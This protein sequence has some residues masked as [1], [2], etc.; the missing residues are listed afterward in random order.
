MNY[1][2]SNKHHFE[3]KVSTIEN[4]GRIFEQDKIGLYSSKIKNICDS[5]Y[6]PITKITS[7]GIILIYS[8]YLDS[9]LVPI[10]LTLEEM[11][12]KRFNNPSLF[13]NN[14]KQVD[15][16]TFQTKDKMK[17][18]TFHPASY[19]MITGDKNLSPNNK[20]DIKMV[21]SPK[22]KNGE[23]VKI[24]LISKAGSEGIDFKNIR[25][26]HLLDPWYNM[27]RNDQT[28]GR[29]VRNNS[30]T[31]LPFIKRNVQVYTYGTILKIPEDE[32]AD[33]YVYRVAEQKSI[34]MGKI[35][36]IIKEN[37]VDCII[38][39][40]QNNYTQENIKKILKKPIKQT[41][42]T[43]ETIHDFYVG[44]TPNTP[45]C[46][47]M[48]DCEYHCNIPNRLEVNKSTYN[49]YNEHFILSNSERLIQ[50]IKNLFKEKFFYIKKS[51]VQI[52]QYP[53]PYPIIQI[54]AALTYLIESPT[55][56]LIDIFGRTGKLVNIEEYY[57]FQPLELKNNNISILDRSVPIPYKHHSIKISLKEEYKN[58]FEKKQ[59]LPALDTIHEEKE[60]STSMI[61]DL[62]TK[63]DLVM[64]FSKKK[65]IKIT[66][67]MRW[68]EH[69]GFMM[70]I[71]H[72]D[73]KI[74]KDLL[75]RFIIEHWVDS[76]IFEDKLDLYQLIYSS[77]KLNDIELQIKQYLDE[78]IIPIKKGKELGIILSNGVELLYYILKK[79]KW[80]EAEEL[81]KQEIMKHIESI[82]IIFGSYIGF[83]SYDKFNQHL[84]FKLRNNSNK[85][86]KGAR[87]DEA[88]KKNN[89]KILNAIL[90]K[91][92]YTKEN[93]NKYNNIDLCI[94]QEMLLRYYNF[95]K[96]KEK[97]WF[98]YPDL[99]KIYNL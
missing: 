41:L 12:I 4:Y 83:F 68:Y 59:K 67:D 32:S 6:N 64:E 45:L 61:Q 56:Y 71:I 65:D 2:E 81:D 53:K 93:T 18:K 35:S 10:A 3:Y 69:Y 38:N 77:E 46:D 70:E 42:S 84:I 75:F 34:Q 5:I 78:Q 21:T 72:T 79:H 90:E 40:E 63:Y 49:T 58:I 91:E 9:G 80:I 30:H 86:N 44:D 96:F 23:I 25:Q 11:G 98:L 52:L 36:R 50:K 39:H 26:V 17:G 92:I 94:Q 22:N 55:E 33:L 62:I 37:S 24:V 76:L 43:G 19:I 16:N 74:P 15:S 99:I 60:E 57:L 87:C 31:S 20:K 48:D 8:H 1:N 27:N 88:N 95:T 28:I 7:E 85:R 97:K 51:L 89:I 54:Y 14:T 47:Y 13:E 29:A 82:K 73:L 66:T